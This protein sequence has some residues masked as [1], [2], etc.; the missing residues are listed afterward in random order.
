[1]AAASPAA[2]RA[3]RAG[4]RMVGRAGRGRHRPGGRTR[5]TTRALLGQHRDPR[6][7]GVDPQEQG[8]EVEASSEAMTI[9]PSST[10]RSRPPIQGFF[11]LEGSTGSG[12]EVPALDVD[13]GPVAEDEGPEPVPLRLVAPSLAPGISGC[14]LASIG[15]MGA[16]LETPRTDSS[17]PCR[18]LPASGHLPPIPRRRRRV[19]GSQF[20]LTVGDRRLL[21]DCGLF[22][23]GM[24][25]IARN[26]MAFSYAADDVHAVL[27]THAHNDHIGR[28]P[29]SS[30]RDIAGRCS[31]P[32][33]PRPVR[34]RARRQ[35]PPAGPRRGT[36]GPPPPRQPR[37][38][39]A[40]LRP[41]LPRPEMAAVAAQAPKPP[42]MH[43]ESRP[44]VRPGRRPAHDR[45]GSTGRLRDGDADHRRRRSD[46]HDAG[47][48][49][50][51][52]IIELRVRDQR[53]TEQTIVFSGDLGRPDTPILRTRH[54]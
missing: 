41:P 28:L 33:P 48:I 52:A 15:S 5:R 27:L 38:R 42:P 20:L 44:A 6:R 24:E 31:R 11:E 36:L 13:L 35:R 18:I 19:T 25:E 39:P 9:S 3:R 51:S 23:G 43:T 54:R 32:M 40:S 14:G 16:R 49:L 45:D 7:G 4:R 46:F 26:R 1:M 2:A 17:R 53:G 30:G 22:Q 29:A 34:D 50:G 21:V 47:H 12:L 10:N 37:R 8:V